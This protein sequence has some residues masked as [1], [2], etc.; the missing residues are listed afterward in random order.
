M[1]MFD[2]KK[3]DDE[4]L[5]EEALSEMTAER[6]G[7]RVDIDTM[8]DLVSMDLLFPLE[9]LAEEYGTSIQEALEDTLKKIRRWYLQGYIDP[10]V[11]LLQAPVESELSAIDTVLNTYRIPL[12]LGCVEPDTELPI[13]FLLLT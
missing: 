11:L 7:I 8:A 3:P 13:M 4:D 12:E 2:D 1:V 10:D 6:L 5:V 9:D